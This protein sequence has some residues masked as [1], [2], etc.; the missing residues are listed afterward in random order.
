MSKNCKNRKKEKQNKWEKI[1][2]AGVQTQMFANIYTGDY[3]NGK[4]VTHTHTHTHSKMAIKFG[5][6]GY[7]EKARTKLKQKFEGIKSP[8]QGFQ[9]SSFTAKHVSIQKRKFKTFYFKSS[10]ISKGLPTL[11]LSLKNQQ[12]DTDIIFNVGML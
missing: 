11:L 6:K 5:E 7:P 8:R 3:L 4:R 10:T 2:R 1:I 9:N 12:K